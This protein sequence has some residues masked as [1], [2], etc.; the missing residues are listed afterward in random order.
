M[1][2]HL[3]FGTVSRDA[4]L[5]LAERIFGGEKSRAASPEHRA[6]FLELTDEDMENLVIL[7]TRAQG[8][9]LVRAFSRTG[10]QPIQTRVGG[11]VADTLT[12]V[13]TGLASFDTFARLRF[14]PS[15]GPRPDPETRRMIQNKIYAAEPLIARAAAD[16]V[17]EVLVIDG[18][19][20]SQNPTKKAHQL[21]SF[22]N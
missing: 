4:A 14:H 15:A 6:Q 2:S 11:V 8:K 18:E 19:H 3:R 9:E 5:R 16:F 17:R 21:C 13:A 12:A 7:V 20:A 22:E 1:F 10:G